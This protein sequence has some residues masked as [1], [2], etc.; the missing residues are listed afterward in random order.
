M[1]KNN[2]PK[3]FSCT[4]RGTHSPRWAGWRWTRF[5][6]VPQR[7]PQAAHSRGGVSAQAIHRAELAF[8]LVFG[9]LSGRCGAVSDPVDKKA[10][11]GG[12]PRSQETLPQETREREAMSR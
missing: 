1:N 11:T 10:G 4:A 5:R 12:V 6:D 2:V 7:Y 9:T 8:G 3:F